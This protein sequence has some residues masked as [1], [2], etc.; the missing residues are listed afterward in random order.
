MERSQR[1]LDLGH[2]GSDSFSLVPI[3]SSTA[4]H[5]M[6]M[7]SPALDQDRRFAVD[8]VSLIVG[9]NEVINQFFPWFQIISAHRLLSIG[10]RCARPQVGPVCRYDLEP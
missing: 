4:G 3:G 7:S 9:D 6:W 2:G 1:S 10:P 8:I 5:K